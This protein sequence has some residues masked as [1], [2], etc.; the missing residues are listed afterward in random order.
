MEDINVKPQSFI[1]FYVKGAPLTKAEMAAI[2]RVRKRT[3]SYKGLL[4]LFKR[5]QPTAL[6]PIR[7]RRCDRPLAV[8]G[9]AEMVYTDSDAVKE[10]Y[11]KAGIPVEPI[12]KKVKANGDNN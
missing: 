5:G 3:R 11:K 2:E 8:Y 7:I 10:A 1:Y 4:G 9:N 6:R 12:S